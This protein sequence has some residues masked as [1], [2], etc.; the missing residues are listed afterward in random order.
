LL[1]DWRAGNR[2]AGARVALERKPLRQIAWGR[3]SLMLIALSLFLSAC[4]HAPRTPEP[5]DIAAPSAKVSDGAPAQPQ[6]RDIGPVQAR[7]QG[8]GLWPY[9]Q[10]GDTLAVFPP[11][12]A[13]ERLGRASE[14]RPGSVYTYVLYGLGDGRRPQQTRPWRHT[15]LE[16]LRLID[17]YVIG[18]PEVANQDAVAASHEFLVPV[19]AGLDP[20]PLAERSAPDLAD[21]AREALAAR[22]DARRDNALA[23]RLRSASGPF[24]VS[25]TTPEL[26]PRNGE[27]PLLLTDLSSIGPENLYPVVDAYDRPV[28]AGVAGTSAALEELRQRLARMG[29]SPGRGKDDAWVHL[30]E[31]SAGGSAQMSKSMR[32]S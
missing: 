2:T 8:D 9:G 29:A 25:R 10:Q 23:N 20:L 22:L 14:H 21:G 24:L 19:Y 3:A 16:L 12:P 7:Q 17:T 1:P 26:L 4:G 6:A 15:E 28:S 18:A 32:G 11:L 30:L 13:A 5:A 31:S 27:A